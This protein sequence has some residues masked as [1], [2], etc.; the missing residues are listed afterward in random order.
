[1]WFL[2]YLSHQRGGLVKIAE[3]LL[4]AFPEQFSPTGTL[5]E[6]MS[7]FLREFC[8]NPAQ[9]LSA[10]AFPHLKNLYG[11]LQDYCSQV[12]AARL[13]GRSTTPRTRNRSCSLKAMHV[14]ANHL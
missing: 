3:D 4:A 2:Q 10:V 1:M 5:L 14:S 7:N 9:A 6:E 11:V 13:G 8:L 12:A